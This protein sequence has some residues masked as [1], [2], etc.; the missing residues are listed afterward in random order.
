[1]RTRKPRPVRTTLDL[2]D[3]AQV[4]LVRKRLGVTNDDLLR[5]AAKIGNSIAAISKEIEV[6]RAA[7][8]VPLS[9]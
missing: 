8:C 6:E 9:D 3:E 2:A 7:Q 5:I 1:M 4:R